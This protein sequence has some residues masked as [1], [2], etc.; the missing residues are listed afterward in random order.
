MQKP[1]PT[2]LTSP[3]APL[4]A[5]NKKAFPYNIVTDIYSTNITVTM[6]RLPAPP[7]RVRGFVADQ[8]YSVYSKGSLC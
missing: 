6:V 8:L 1:M 4:K 2:A 7:T 3:L 5:L